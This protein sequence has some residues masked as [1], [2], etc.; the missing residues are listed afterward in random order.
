MTT[1]SLV[2]NP[3]TDEEL[4]KFEKALNKID[5][6]NLYTQWKDEVPTILEIGYR[7]IYALRHVREVLATRK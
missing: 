5:M 4:D 7:T 6:C 1:S 3:P 2:M